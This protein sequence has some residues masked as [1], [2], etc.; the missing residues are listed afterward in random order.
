MGRPGPW[1][2]MA[3]LKVTSKPFMIDVQLCKLLDGWNVA[4]AIKL[5]ET[6]SAAA[7]FPF[8]PVRQSSFA[9]SAHFGT[10]GRFLMFRS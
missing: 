7:T 8:T 1:G 10:I 9:A 4:Q 5:F 3:F 6:P 2:C